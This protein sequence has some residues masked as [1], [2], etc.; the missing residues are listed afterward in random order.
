VR[1]RLGG[2]MVMVVVQGHL[3]DGE[4][5]RER[6]SWSCDDEARAQLTPSNALDLSLVP[7]A[8]RPPPSFVTMKQ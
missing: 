2:W 8:L 7:V 5:N 1:V 6:A 4:F 3:L